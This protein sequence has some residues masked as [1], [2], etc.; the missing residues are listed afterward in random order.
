MQKLA[1]ILG[2]AVWSALC[3]RTALSVHFLL[4]ESKII[5]YEAQQAGYDLQF[6]TSAPVD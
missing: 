3:F 2:G 5:Q 1:W 6:M 4:M